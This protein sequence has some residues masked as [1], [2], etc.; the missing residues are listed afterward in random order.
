MRN[1]KIEIEDLDLRPTTNFGAYKESIAHQSQ[2][3]KSN[4]NHASPE[5]QSK[6]V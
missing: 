1:D 3:Q 6:T 4:N 5:L 2:Y